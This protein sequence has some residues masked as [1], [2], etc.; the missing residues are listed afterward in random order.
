MKVPFASRR[1]DD[2][3]VGVADVLRGR[4][5]DCV[6][7]SCGRPVVARQ[8][9]IRAWHF[10]HEFIESTADLC[11]YSVEESVR[12]AILWLLPKL[13]RLRVPAASDRTAKHVE[14]DCVD[15]KVAVG[16]APVDARVISEGYELHLYIT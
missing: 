8:G 1:S 5:A 12:E 9:D 2:C 4:A 15:M 13:D 10:A 3:I 16:S 11:K 6:C 14:P 7:L